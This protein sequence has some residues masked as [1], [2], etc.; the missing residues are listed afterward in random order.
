MSTPSGLGPSPH[1]NKQG[2]T[3]SM[4]DMHS[5]VEDLKQRAVFENLSS[6]VTKCTR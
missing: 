2:N 4:T 1:A 5:F 3:Q 6:L